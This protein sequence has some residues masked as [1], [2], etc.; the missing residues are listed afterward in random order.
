MQF[1]AS[2][3]ELLSIKRDSFLTSF[4]PFFY[5]TFFFCF[6][7]SIL[8]AVTFFLSCFLLLS[9]ILVLKK[10]YISFSLYFFYLPFSV[11]IF[12]PQ[13]KPKKLEKML[14]Q[15]NKHVLFSFLIVN[16]SQFFLVFITCF[17]LICLIF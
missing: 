4:P 3:F 7:C 11:F 15:L 10:N 14:L 2:V 6:S 5:T 9:L 12:P 13:F 1:N 17:D 16:F 8:L